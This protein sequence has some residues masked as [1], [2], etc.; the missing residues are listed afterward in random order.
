MH[1]IPACTR[2]TNSNSEFLK[3]FVDFD[4][5]SHQLSI[6]ISNNTNTYKMSCTSSYCN[7][8]VI[9]LFLLE[10]QLHKHAWVNLESLKANTFRSNYARINCTDVISLV[11]AS[12][13]VYYLTIQ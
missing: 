1:R 11:S 4:L 6:C 8:I 12:C 13:R 5:Q 3:L 9:A 2:Y 10:Q 7:C